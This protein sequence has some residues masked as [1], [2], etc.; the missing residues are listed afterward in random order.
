MLNVD[1]NNT[2]FTSSIKMLWVY[3]IPKMTV[4]LEEECVIKVS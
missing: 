3:R 4:L 1:G 2:N